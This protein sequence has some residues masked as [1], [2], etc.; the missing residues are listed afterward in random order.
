[1]LTHFFNKKFYQDDV[2][3]QQN[4][5]SDIANVYQDGVPYFSPTTPDMDVGDMTMEM[6]STVPN[7]VASINLPS[8]YK[9]TLPG[10][11][12]VILAIAT[13]PNVYP[14]AFAPYE[15][16]ALLYDETGQ[17]VIGTGLIE[18]NFYFTN[19]V[20]AKRIIQQAGG[21]PNN[22]TEFNTVMNTLEKS[23]SGWQ[24]FLGFLI[25]LLPLWIILIMIAVVFKSKGDKKIKAMFM[26]AILLILYVFFTRVIA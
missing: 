13:A 21:D 9:I 10:G 26:V 5:S 18:A 17:N 8:K 12:K 7:P 16:P 11:K 6:V 24:K 19:D 25:G 2:Q 1:M 23:Q 3:L 20:F 15:T 4:I 14:T 22:P